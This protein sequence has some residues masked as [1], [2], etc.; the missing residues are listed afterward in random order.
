VNIAIRT[1]ASLQIGTGHVMRCLT[2]AE[3]LRKKGAQVNFICRRHKGNL[4]DR[5]SSQGF[6]VH[7]LEVTENSVKPASPGNL[8]D[9]NTLSHTQWLAA[10]QTQDADECR[11]LLD[12]ISPDWL[13]VDHYGIDQAWQLALKGTYKKLMV[14]DDLADRNH[15]CDLLLDQTYGRLPQDYLDMV[16][17]HC[18][19]L[20]GSRYALLRPEFAQWRRYSLDRRAEPQ[21]KNLLISMGGVDPHNVTGGVLDALKT[22]ELPKDLEITVVM[23]E[24]TP[25]LEVVQ[26]Q[27]KEMPYKTQV[28]VGVNNMAEIM[29]N[30]DLAIGAAGATTWERCCLGLPSILMVLADNQIIIAQLISQ[31]NAAIKLEVN[32]LGELCE[33]L[34]IAENKLESLIL[35]SA[36][37]TNGK[38]TVCT[39]GCIL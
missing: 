24:T 12:A 6:N 23:G 18:Q 11:P 33:F 30:A 39:V 2:L 19:L 4:T 22:C 27:A 9:E 29:S 16:P 36:K 31:A 35:N 7:V 8:E 20:L 25:H 5:I 13:I 14:I 37:V 3:A 21:L 15:Q 38:G 1:D 28:K 34:T 17:A 10:S 32:Q 26:S